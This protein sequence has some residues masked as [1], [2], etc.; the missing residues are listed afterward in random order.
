MRYSLCSYSLHRTFD[1]GQ[2]DLFGY[3]RFCQEAGYTQLDP[4]NAH[5]KQS[6]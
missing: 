5:L 1:A 2:M 4:W 6:V 3:F